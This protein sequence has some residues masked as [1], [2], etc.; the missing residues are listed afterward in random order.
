M[1]LRRRNLRSDMSSRLRGEV[2]AQIAPVPNLEPKASNAHRISGERA[3]LTHSKQLYEVVPID[4]NYLIADGVTTR[5]TRPNR[6][7]IYARVAALS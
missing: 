5:Q 2:R 1:H 6:S 7:S 4:S 3:Y